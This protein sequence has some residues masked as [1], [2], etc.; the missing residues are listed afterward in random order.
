MKLRWLENLLESNNIEVPTSL[1][2]V[3]MLV[4]VIVIIGIMIYILD[5]VKP[6]T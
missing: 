2:I 4:L 1:G 3:I 6:P 5:S